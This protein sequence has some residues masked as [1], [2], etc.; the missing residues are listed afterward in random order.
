MSLRLKYIY[1][2]F[3][4]MIFSSVQNLAEASS[5]KSY[6]SSELDMPC[7]YDKLVR[8]LS[9]DIHE[10]IIDEDFS[11]DV[12]KGKINTNIPRIIGDDISFN[13]KT[14]ITTQIEGKSIPE[15]FIDAYSPME[16]L[17]G[18]SFNFNNHACRSVIQIR[19]TAPFSVIENISIS[20]ID[21]RGCPLV[22]QTYIIGLYVSLTDGSNVKISRI[23]AN[24]LSS[25]SNSIIGD[26]CGNISAVYLNAESNAKVHLEL[27][28]CQFKDIHNFDDKRRLILEDTNGLYAHMSYPVHPD[29]KVHI[30]D[31]TGVDYGKRLIKTDCSNLRVENIYASSK[32]HDTLSA[33]S[34]NDGDGKPYSNA[35]I[36]NVHF[37]GTTQYVVGSSIPNTV[38][39]N[40]FS[41]ITIAPESISA[42]IQPSA[43]CY[44]ENLKLRGAQLIASI[45]ATDKPVVIKN[46]DYD[47]TMYNH[48]TYGSSLFLTK[49]AN[50]TLSDLRIKSD[51][52][53]YIFFDN[54]FNQTS[55][56]INVIARI[57]NMT[58]DLYKRSKD[59]LLVMNGRNHVW[60][61]AINNSVIV[62]NE[63][64]RGLI[65][66]VPDTA[67]ARLMRLSMS[68]V[69]IIYNDLD[70]SSTIPFGTLTLGK[71][72]ELA[73]RNVNVIN[74][75]G[76]SFSDALYSF[77]V[78]NLTDAVTYGNLS[79]SGCNIEQCKDGM[80][81]LFV[82]GNNIVWSGG[83]CITHSDP[84]SITSLTRKHKKFSCKDMNGK[85]YKWNGRKWKSVH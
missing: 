69:R 57:D 66:I 37:T 47:D 19:N 68:D 77:Y 73:L 82:N 2:A 48:G 3:C 72:T 13:I 53:S 58:M 85:I 63:P 10:L 38:I 52:L 41:E 33:V 65:G 62:F 42:A 75:S 76:K 31:I 78:K 43:G 67:E 79:I 84:S 27:F 35:V 25:T 26:S 59:W 12:F 81:G 5:V 36:D 40:I 74:Q 20:S 49:D 28:D 34:L 16:Y 55:Y 54:Y 23:S 32:Y 22:Q 8:L 60:D 46:V 9:M 24:E 18:I 21:I 50:I 56:D 45:V 7:N 15:V 1:V 64:F 44:V 30:H 71:N 80:S 4:C 83:D 51:K 14:D 70:V 39:S 17:G 6:R 11:I 61:L 29:T